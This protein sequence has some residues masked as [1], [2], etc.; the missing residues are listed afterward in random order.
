MPGRE[1]D[2]PFI[3]SDMMQEFEVVTAFLFQCFG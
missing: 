2:N 1:P 3:K